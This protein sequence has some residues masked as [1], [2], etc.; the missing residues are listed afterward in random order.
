MLTEGIGGTC[1]NCDYKNM[2]Y[3]YGSDGYYQLDACP[4][5]GFAY[6]NCSDGNDT[7]DKVWK[8]IIDTWKGELDKNKFPHSR[9]GLYLWVEK[10]MREYTGPVDERGTVFVYSPKDVSEIMNHVKNKIIYGKIKVMLF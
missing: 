9:R 3:R 7:G 4:S 10:L 2:F 8:V 1:P 5:C 6:A